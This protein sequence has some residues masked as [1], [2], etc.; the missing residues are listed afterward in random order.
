MDQWAPLDIL[1]VV[2]VFFVGA[3]TA[4]WDSESESGEDEAS[5]V[6]I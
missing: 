5:L 1:V 3:S 4:H 6:H 2:L